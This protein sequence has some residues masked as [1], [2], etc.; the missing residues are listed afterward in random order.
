MKRTRVQ[1]QRR[2]TCTAVLAMRPITALSSD[3]LE[4]WGN[5]S[6][7]VLADFYGRQEHTFTDPETKTQQTSRSQPELDG[8]K[9]KVSTYV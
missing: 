4:E 5:E 7:D 9:L 2:M 3:D 8:L 1:P 6:I